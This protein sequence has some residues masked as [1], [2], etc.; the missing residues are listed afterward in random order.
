[1]S[2]FIHITSKLTG[3]KGGPPIVNLRLK[4]LMVLT[5]SGVHKRKF[6]KG[7]QFK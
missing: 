4:C 3:R 2:V 5:F 7:D 6:I 1:M